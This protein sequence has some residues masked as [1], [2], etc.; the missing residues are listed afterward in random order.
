MQPQ[1]PPQFPTQPGFLAAP[2]YPPAP[3]YP[4]APQYAPAPQYP[5][6]Q[7]YPQPAYAPPAPPAA[8]LPTGT[9]DAYYEQPSGGAPSF[10]FMDANRNP[11][12]GKQYIGVVARPVTDADI[13]A[14]TAESGRVST[15]RDGRSKFV[16]IVPMN[17]QPSAE[18]TDGQ[19]GWWV[20]GQARDELARAMAEAGAPAG[21]P[22]MGATIRVTLTGTRQIPGRNPQFIFRVDYVRPAGAT[23]AP[24]APAAQQPAPVQHGPDTE[25]G[26]GPMGYPPAVMQPVPAQPMGWPPVGQEQA[27]AFAAGGM[28]GLMAAQAAQPAPSFATGGPV[29]PPAPAVMQPAVQHPHLANT[30]MAPPVQQVQPPV[31]QAPMAPVQPAPVMPA[32]APQP[33]VQPAATAVAPAGQAPAFETAEQAEL[34]ARITGGQPAPAAG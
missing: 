20:K 4:P 9:L 23:S 2:Q 17:V 25:Y 19:A 26:Q 15:F 8:P 24:V 11:L 33:P 16:M 7:A 13:R 5:P 32:P 28:P 22:E 12:I 6:Q 34:W 3:V 31:A 1:Y 27:A 18:F 10:K 30:L 29:Y 14:Q 21:P